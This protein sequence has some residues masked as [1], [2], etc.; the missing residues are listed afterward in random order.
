M[1][2]Y[3]AIYDAVRSKISGG[4][5][6]QAVA[7]ACDFSFQAGQVQQAW[8]EAAYEQQRPFVVLRPRMLLDGDQWCALY[9]EDLQ[10]GVVGFGK[11]PAEA[12]SNFDAKWHEKLPE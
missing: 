3:Q 1:S 11:S 12:A 4:D 5:I 10:N 7:R 9:G 2:D 6:S 8:Q